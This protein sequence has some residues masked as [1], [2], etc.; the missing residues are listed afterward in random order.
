M[1]NTSTETVAKTKTSLPISD[2]TTDNVLDFSTTLRELRKTVDPDLVRQ[3]AARRDRDGN[4]QMEDYV[5]WHTV[6]D[7]LDETAPNWTH[8]IKNISPLIHAASSDASSTT[9]GAI[10]CGWPMR[11]SGVCVSICLRKSLSESPAE[12]K[13][14]VSTIPGFTEFTRIFFGPSSVARLRVTASTAAFVAL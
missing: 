3:R 7:I 12:W 1:K 9:I 11:P 6:A 4:I 14:S 8:E 13:P 2:E 10:S 5:E